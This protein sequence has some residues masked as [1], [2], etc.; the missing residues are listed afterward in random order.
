M[1]SHRE[2]RRGGETGERRET[3]RGTEVRRKMMQ[4]NEEGETK[5]EEE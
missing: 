4:N 1:V 5:G 3:V 2:G